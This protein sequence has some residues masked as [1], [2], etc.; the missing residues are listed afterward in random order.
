MIVH[1]P[2]KRAQSTLDLVQSNSSCP[3]E[4]S[5]SKKQ[6]R[7]DIRESLK[8]IMAQVENDENNSALSNQVPVY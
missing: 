6:V 3:S 5:N 8:E 7:F 1:Y 2:Y 4:R